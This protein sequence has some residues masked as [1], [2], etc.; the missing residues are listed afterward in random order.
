MNTLKQVTRELRMMRNRM[1]ATKAI[2]R[3]K[4]KLDHREECKSTLSL[5]LEE[6]AQRRMVG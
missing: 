5:K 3:M 1:K 6:K 4:H 2:L